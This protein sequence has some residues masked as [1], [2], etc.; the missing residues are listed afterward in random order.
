MRKKIPFIAL[1][2]ALLCGVL[3]I[4]KWWSSM[5]ETRLKNRVE[6]ELL[7]ELPDLANEDWRLYMDGS[8]GI[9]HGT[10]STEALYQEVSAL[11]AQMTGDGAEKIAGL[12]DLRCALT[13]PHRSALKIEI[14]DHTGVLTIAGDVPAQAEED[15]SNALASAFPMGKLDKQLRVSSGM[16][17]DAPWAIPL[18]KIL[19]KLVRSVGDLSMEL[20]G[21][22]IIIQGQ[23]A[24]EAARNRI[25]NLLLGDLA[26][27]IDFVRNGLTTLEGDLD[28]SY[29][30]VEFTDADTLVLHGRVES[31]NAH[32]R[33]I[34]GLES[35]APPGVLIEDR[36]KVRPSAGGGWWARPT[37]AFL[38]E[39]FK[40]MHS[41]EFHVEPNSVK[42][43]CEA[44]A[45]D[46]TAIR[47]LAD[48]HFPSL[49][50]AVATELRGMAEPAATL[51][52]SSNTVTSSPTAV[53]VDVP[54]THDV[55][56]EI[57]LP[58]IGDPLVPEKVDPVVVAETDAPEPSTPDTAKLEE[59]V[60][61]TQ[62]FFSSGST[63]VRE[64]ER[65]K[66]ID[67]A[68]L[69]AEAPQIKLD[70]SGLADPVGNAAANR[71]LAKK[72]CTSVQAVLEDAG[73]SAQR[74]EVVGGGE[75]SP[76]ADEPSWMLRRVEFAIQTAVEPALVAEGDAPTRD[77]ITDMQI[78]FQKSSTKLTDDERTKLES[79]ASFLKGDNSGVLGISGFTDPGGNRYYN[80]RLSKQRC[81]TV[82]DFLVERGIP[83]ERLKTETGGEL[84]NSESNEPTWKKRRVQFQWVDLARR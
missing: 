78:Y 35:I 58:D 80:E 50:Y 20:E 69:L 19:P 23:V 56:D 5:G 52:A 39:A 2:L 79:I 65:E 61:S 32:D 12:D 45:K 13:V 57:P 84:A 22:S 8:N 30:T 9:I 10:V 38:P 21:R 47:S 31:E 62:I 60:A 18:G 49:T 51:L 66:L 24:D 55:I 37:L 82:H 77:S 17:S 1:A 16:V 44:L 59:L 72:R 27:S 29:L 43:S 63:R 42:I 81:Q 40:L 7:D 4:P 54:G 70:I 75:K 73:I 3:A 26:G 67:L 11:V 74:L 76:S 34:R 41:G 15:L 68:D 71:R 36:L 33:L 25:Q 83:T 64:A 14:N 53:V 48:T 46:Q 6:Y 28:R